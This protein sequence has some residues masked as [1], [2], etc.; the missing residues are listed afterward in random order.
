VT[1]SL[2]HFDSKTVTSSSIK[3]VLGSLTIVPKP[4]LAGRSKVGRTLSIKKNLWGQGVTLK[5]QW[6][7]DGV[8]IA[9]ATKPKYKL[10]KKDLGHKISVRIVSSQPGYFGVTRITK[11]TKKVVK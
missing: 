8:K 5:Y 9:K 11:P 7:R 4:I 3:V 10:S 1:G 2:D 6:L